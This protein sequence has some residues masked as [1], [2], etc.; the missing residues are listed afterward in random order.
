MGALELVKPFVE[1]GR[2]FRVCPKD[3]AACSKHLAHGAQRG[4]IPSKTDA[5]KGRDAAQACQRRLRQAAQIHLKAVRNVLRKGVILRCPP[6]DGNRDAAANA[7]LL[8]DRLHRP[9][10]IQRDPLAHAAGKASPIVD[11]LQP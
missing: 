4:R 7:T 2:P 1:I 3:L 11:K 6:D 8:L 9:T 10:Q 5:P